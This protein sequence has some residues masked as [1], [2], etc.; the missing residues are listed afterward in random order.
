MSGFFRWLVP[1]SA[2]SD[3]RASAVGDVSASR[4]PQG[5]SLRRA[6]T[7]APPLGQAAHSQSVDGALRT[8]ARLVIPHSACHQQSVPL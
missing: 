7:V 6:E 1:H 3:Q 5:A 2:V 4:V 8:M